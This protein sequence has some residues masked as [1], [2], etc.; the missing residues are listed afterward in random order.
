[1]VQEGSFSNKLR[2]SPHLALRRKELSCENQPGSTLGTTKAARFAAW[3]L[4][5]IIIALSAVPAGLRPVTGAP[6]DFEHFA[7]YWAAGLAFGL[8]YQSRHG[9]LAFMLVGFAGSIEIGQ[10]FVPGRHARL[11]DFIVDALAM[12]VGV[13]MASLVNQ[14]RARLIWKRVSGTPPD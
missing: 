11:G 5:V 7:A 9:L 13:A 6:H 2:C 8:G 14:I 10:W 12:C 1:M 3:G 4:A